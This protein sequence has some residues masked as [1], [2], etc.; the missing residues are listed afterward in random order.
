MCT[1]PFCGH[2]GRGR[3]EEE[4]DLCLPWAQEEEW[5]MTADGPEGSFWSDGKCSRTGL[6]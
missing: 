6:C 1:V 2:S 4:V 5:G 3:L